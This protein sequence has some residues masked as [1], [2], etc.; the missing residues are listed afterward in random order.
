MNDRGPATVKERPARPEN[1][2]CRERK[3]DP[4][5]QLTGQEMLQRVTV[6]WVLPEQG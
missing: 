2:W 4:S 1:H 6:S 5:E 3:L